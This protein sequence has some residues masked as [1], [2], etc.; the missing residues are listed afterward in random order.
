MEML[1]N[2]LVEKVDKVDDKVKVRTKNCNFEM[3]LT[4]DVD[5]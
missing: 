3:I 4:L 5:H 1:L 2:G